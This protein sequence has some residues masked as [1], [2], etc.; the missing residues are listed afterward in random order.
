MKIATNT[1]NS[2]K[3][4]LVL[5]ALCQVGLS[6]AA[7]ANLTLVDT[8]KETPESTAHILSVASVKLGEPGLIDLLRL[9][10]TNPAP[11]GSLFTISY[12]TNG[13]ADISWNLA[14]SGFDLLA[15]YIF[16]GSNGANLYK[17]T[18]AAQMISGSATINTPLTGNSGQFAGISHTLFL[19]VPTA[20]VPEPSSVM[21]LFAGAASAFIWRR[22][23]G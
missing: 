15:V 6:T 21:L 12:T 14:G 2:W 3:L 22:R 19:G 23:R 9:E 11:A 4:G 5:A 18:D 10:D 16:G 20:S 13:T 1:S 17:V 7:R 8:Y